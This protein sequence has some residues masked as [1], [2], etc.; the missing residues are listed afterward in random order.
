M[1]GS[2]AIVLVTMVSLPWTTP[3]ADAATGDLDVPLGDT[4]VQISYVRTVESTD[5]ITDT[6]GDGYTYTSYPWEWGRTRA[7]IR[8]SPG[9]QYYSTD[10]V[11]GSG[12]QYAAVGYG[13]PSWDQSSCSS[14]YRGESAD[15]NQTSLGFQPS[16]T[17]SIKVGQVFLVGRMRHVNSPIYTDS[18][19]VT[20]PS[21]GGTA[22]FGSFNI[23]TAG[24][25][26]A[27]FPWKEFDTI[28]T[29]TG[30]IGSDGKLII[31]DYAIDPNTVATP[32]A[33]DW[34]GNVGAYDGRTYTYMYQ[35][36]SLVW[37]NGYMTQHFTDKNG[38]SCADDILDIK[39]DRSDTA[40][41]DPNTGI[42]Y[43]LKLWGFVNNG[44]SQQCHAELEKAQTS[45]L[46]ERFITR[47]N[48]TSYGCL[49]GSIEQERPVTFAKDVKA[50]PS[51]RGTLTIPTFNYVNAS[52]EGTYG[53][54]KWGT[55]N[56]LTPTWD[57][58]AV[59]PNSYALLAP[60]DAAT[61]QEAGASPQ[62]A[63][64][65]KTGDV[66]TS[67]W[68]LR[69]VTCTAG[70]NGVPLLRRDG[71]T[72]L[73]Q[74]DSVNLD[75]RTIR[76]DET[77]LAEHQD[78]VAVKCV[79]HNEYVVGRGRVTL[80]TV[81][82]GGNA[83]PNQWTMTAKPA[84]EGLF[85]QKTITGASGTPD[86][87][88]VYTAGGTYA[89]STG[90]GPE[91][92]TQNGPWVCTDDDG[93]DVPVS[94]D[95]QF[96][97]REGRN[98]TCVVHQKPQQT[99][100]SAVKS[101]DGASDA[102]TA[103]S[104][105]LSY[106]C[107]PGPD[108]KATSTG[109]I[110]VDAKGN[111]ADLPAQR[112][113]ATCT[114]TEDAR[115]AKGLK[116]PG[117]PAGGSLSWKDPAAFKVITNPGRGEKELA[118]T[119]VAPANGNAGGVTFTV[120][121]ST[122]GAVRIKV[123]NSVIPHAG[124]DKT[125]TK[126]AKSAEKVNG[127]TT[128]DQTYTITVTNPSA[129]AGLTYD[130]ND[131]WQVPNGVTVHKVSIS[132]GAITGTETPQAGV[133]YAKTGITLAAGQKHT[134]TVVLNVSGPDAGL[135]GVQ[136][137]CSPGAVGQGK[138]IYNKASV[139]TKGDGQPKEAAA[140]GTLPTNPQFKASKTPL[141]VVRNADGTFTSSYTVTVTN[142]SL[143]ASPVV[144]DLTDTPQMPTGT[145]L[146]KVRILEKGVDAQGVTLPGRNDTTG[147][148][149]G[150]ITLIKAGTGETLAAAPRAGGE[151]GSRTFTMQ[152]TFTVR[153]N[154]PGFNESDFQCGHQRADGKP[155]GLVNTIAM[156]GDT[157]GEGNNHGCLSTEGKLKFSKEIKTQPGNGTT[158]DVVYTVS[159]V[160]EGSLTVS[161][162]PIN[163]KPSFAPGLNPTVVKV[164]REM[165][166]ARMVAAQ[167]DGSYRL[168]DNEKLYSG[169]MIRYTVTFTVKIDPSAAG[170]SD[171]LLSCTTENGRLVPGHGLYNKVVPQAGKDSDTRPDHDVA[172]AN[173]SPNAGKRIL[174]II[175]TGSQGP[176][177]D[178]AFDIYP[179]DP[180]TP[181]ARPLSDGVTFTGG[182][183]TGTFTTT[184]LAINREY[185]LVETK[186][187]AGHQLMA[188]PARF[189]VTDTGIELINPDPG[190]SALTVSRS[191]AS[192]SE[193]TITVR[194]VQIGTLPLAGGGGIGMNIV[195]GIA[196][197]TGAGLLALRQRK[198]SSFGRSA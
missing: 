111:A 89:L 33:Y 128:F 84:T 124:I 98:V 101:I 177:D 197:I 105:S 114:V 159:V 4:S 48:A 14:V 26:E 64:D 138:A 44:S 59:D 91:G 75:K 193:D 13:R 45:S 31:G 178:A 87:S 180:S 63:V 148:F 112:V 161:T 184:G 49:Y 173:V 163:D 142:T 73:D 123:V 108:G 66:W 188:K 77:Q 3:P 151:G 167:P 71:T 18:S 125:F 130:L 150:P 42:K 30:K 174:S 187:P 52:P 82:D 29:C 189:K 1:V 181:G 126:V 5:P 7:C 79:W 129:K 103:G 36:G 86:V 133:P 104:Y 158:F 67:G 139:T 51:V 131:A 60:N 41:T 176:L 92:Y 115:D 69:N 20:N 93:S 57:N 8:Y 121:D 17:T 27:N 127:Q 50:D 162:G 156:E 56:S 12:G 190:G 78:E 15:K 164:Q 149:N 39:S 160:N 19:R 46:E 171:D 172:C 196:A 88:K 9:S 37:F 102:A 2:L 21:D 192:K 95:S 191:G 47:E 175:K 70:T 100:I 38:R 141:D 83:K 140:C 119:A 58:E 23:R 118:S 40:W 61:V 153:E 99:P 55:P 198:T 94:G 85:G 90:K 185:W 179:M 43:K 166:P 147:T 62:A 194:D 72:R 195:V 81:V 80:V 65:R 25:I 152:M 6:A 113:G 145:Y 54:Q 11:Y 120:P 170:Y 10:T 132:G 146:H 109:K 107:T 97:L 186:A 134:Y 110:T 135:P 143:V 22:Y 165:G 106:T 157:D 155:S 116:Q 16:N 137:T 35:N 168:S 74:S 144:A 154:T 117:S 34:N 183:G 68:F 24:T 182:K 28:N 53:A 136:G 169:L 96:V 122:E 32:Y 76:L